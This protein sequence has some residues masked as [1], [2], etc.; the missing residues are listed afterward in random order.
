MIPSSVS[1]EN[2]STKWNSIGYLDV[3]HSV[4]SGWLGQ[5][6]SGRRR[7][8]YRCSF[9][10]FSRSP[11]QT[12]LDI[13]KQDSFLFLFRMCIPV[14]TLIDGIAFNRQ[15]KRWISLL[16]WMSPTHATI[17][18]SNTYLNLLPTFTTYT[19]KDRMAVCVERRK[20]F[21]IVYAFSFHSER[22]RWH[23]ERNQFIKVFSL[24]GRIFIMIESVY[25]FLSHQWKW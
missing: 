12:F 6:K 24:W 8:Q 20:D 4:H 1:I 25:I 5:E 2:S 21:P 9:N 15:S 3:V 14:L 22:L 11:F 18:R 23:M 10:Y 19:G 17:R 7:W 16:F 13:L